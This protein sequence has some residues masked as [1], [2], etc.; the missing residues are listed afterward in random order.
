MEIPA[1][2]S[3]RFPLSSRLKFTQQ[4]ASQSRL[5]GLYLLVA[6]Q[7]FSDPVHHEEADHKRQESLQEIDPAGF[8]N[9]D[10]IVRVH[11]VHPFCFGSSLTGL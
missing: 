10:D 4:E 3:A 7:Q 1:A 2:S 6:F 11:K 5:N 9:T 8:Q